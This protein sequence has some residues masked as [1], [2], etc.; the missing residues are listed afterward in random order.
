MVLCTYPTEYM[1]ARTPWVNPESTWRLYSAL[2]TSGRCRSSLDRPDPRVMTGRLRTGAGELALVVNASPDE[3]E[4]GLTTAGTTR[5]GRHVAKPGAG[6]LADQVG[7]VRG[8]GAHE[9]RLRVRPHPAWR[10][11]GEA[12]EIR[13][14]GL[15]LPVAQGEHGNPVL[16]EGC[17]GIRTGQVE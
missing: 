5:Y 17:L 2:A 16:R 1:A 13:G 6:P 7:T 12:P 3:L 11:T 14:L 10:H 15:G 4:V 9:T 8:R